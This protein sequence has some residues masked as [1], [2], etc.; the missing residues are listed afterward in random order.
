MRTY[1]RRMWKPLVL[2]LLVAL[3]VTLPPLQAVLGNDE[4]GNIIVVGFDNSSSISIGKENGGILVID[5]SDVEE[6]PISTGG[7]GGGMAPVSQSEETEEDIMSDNE[8][9][10]A[11]EEESKELSEVL[12]IVSTEE[13]VV[14]IIDIEDKTEELSVKMVEDEV[15]NIQPVQDIFVSQST[16]EV[17]TPIMG[18]IMGA[19]GGLIIIGLLIIWKKRMLFWHDV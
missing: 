4:R 5:R 10:M 1:V 13:D 7:G 2:G 3:V 19:I 12:P 17:S 15:A 8:N 9:I 18:I 16:E 6:L 11:V 14:E